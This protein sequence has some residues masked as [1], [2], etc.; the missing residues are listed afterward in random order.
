MVS[1]FPQMV[2]MNSQR[3]DLQGLHQQGRRGAYIKAVIT[4]IEKKKK[5]EG[6]RQT[7]EAFLMWNL[8]GS[9]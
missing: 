2:L 7:T 6:R 1:K 9:G 8:K 3:C 4:V 5:K